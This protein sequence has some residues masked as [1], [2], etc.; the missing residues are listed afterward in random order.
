MLEVIAAVAALATAGAPSMP[1]RRCSASEVRAL[2]GGRDVCLRKGAEYDWKWLYRPL[3]VPA[4]GAGAP[5]PASSASSARGNVAGSGVGFSAFGPG[6]AYPTLENN[7][8]RAAI[9]LVWPPTEPTHIG[10][11]GTKVL[12]EVPRYT[13]AVLI[14]GRQLDGPNEVGFDLGPRWTRT[15]L[16]EIRLVGPTYDLRPAATFVQSPGCYAY[17]VDT[18]RSSYRIVFEARLVV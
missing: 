9:G 10:W 16:R 4:I 15:V 2:V 17:Q 5:C 18:L 3:R 1:E 8:G 7:A 14:R 11:A 6:P 13:G 12:W